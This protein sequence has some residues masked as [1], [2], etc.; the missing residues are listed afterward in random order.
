MFTDLLNRFVR[1]GAESCEA[2]SI[3]EES[4]LR[5]QWLAENLELTKSVLDSIPAN[6]PR[7]CSLFLPRSKRTYPG[8]LSGFAF[9]LTSFIPERA[10]QKIR[11]ISGYASFPA[12][13]VIMKLHCQGLGPAVVAR[14]GEILASA[15]R[16]PSVL[17]FASKARLRRGVP[18]RL[19]RRSD[20]RPC[21]D[22]DS[23]PNQ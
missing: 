2:A 9:A 8:W 16:S 13:G 6:S 11:S 12:L 20:A 17:V 22:R 5:R 18:S 1:I 15:C 23:C 3:R 19:S 7:L 14:V 21:G 4:V 10:Y